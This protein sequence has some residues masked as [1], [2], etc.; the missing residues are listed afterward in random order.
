MRRPL[1]TDCFDV[2][3]SW[4]QLKIVGNRIINRTGKRRLFII[5][6][7]IKMIGEVPSENETSRLENLRLRSIPDLEHFA[8]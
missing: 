2:V 1:F 4:V 3:F 5:A 7:S 8:G 6:Q